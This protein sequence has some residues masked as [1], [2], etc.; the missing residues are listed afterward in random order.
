VLT[1]TIPATDLG[2]VGGVTVTAR[3]RLAAD[4]RSNGLPFSVTKRS[5]TLTFAGLPDRTIVDPP[6]SITATA[7]S[8]LAV[9]YSAS[10]PCSLDGMLVTVTGV[11]SCTITASQPGDATYT[12]AAPVGQTF[13]VRLVSA[14]LPGVFIERGIG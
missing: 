1:A 14:Y 2:A 9:S 7:S 13:T 12:P 8:G 4:S 3:Y 5:Q 11:G 6:F 10:G